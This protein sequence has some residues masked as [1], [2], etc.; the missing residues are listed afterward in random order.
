MI[1]C[2]SPF[3]SRLVSGDQ[4]HV[5]LVLYIQTQPKSILVLV[6]FGYR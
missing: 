1:F 5:A 3:D 6:P 4:Y 2:A